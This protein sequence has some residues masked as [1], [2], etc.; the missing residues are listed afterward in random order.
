MHYRD[1]S[2]ALA[3]M[4][5]PSLIDKNPAHQRGRDTKEMRAARK[6]CAANI[7]ES[8]IDLVNECSGLDG[9]GRRFAAELAAG[10]AAQLVIH[11]RHQAFEGPFVSLAPGQQQAGDV[12][13]VIRQAPTR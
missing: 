11:Q 12:V 9:N 13:E 2:A 5:P 1:P 7:H 6:G 10:N 8:E 3:G 4:S